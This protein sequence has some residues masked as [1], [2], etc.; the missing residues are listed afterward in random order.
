MDMGARSTDQWREHRALLEAIARNKDDGTA[1]PA[2]PAEPEDAAEEPLA[3]PSARREMVGATLLCIAAVLWIAAMLTSFEADGGALVDI[4]NRLSAASGPLALLGIGYLLLQRTSRREARRFGQTA[5]AMRAEAGALE[6]TIARLAARLDDNN[7]A[8]AEQSDRLLRIGEDSALRL[9]E[10]AADMR[11]GSETLTRQADRLEQAAATART[12]IRT[13]VDDLPVAETRIEAI[14]ARINAV[15]TD[16]HQQAATLDAALAALAAQAHAAAGQADE[17]AQRLA[18]RI[19]EIEQMG[20]ATETNIEAASGRM[21]GAIDTAYTGASEAVEQTRKGIEAQGAAMLALIDQ[22]AAVETR[23]GTV[24]DRARELETA[25]AA[26]HAGSNALTEEAGP[27]LVEALLRV[28]ETATQAAER[29]REALAEVIPAATASLGT[30]S[31]EAIE[32]AIGGQIEARM[33]GLSTSAG[34]AI[35]TA[36]KASDV[37]AERIAALDASN[38]AIEARLAEARAQAAAS[39][40]DLFAPRVALL[41]ESL[42]STAIDVAKILSNDV[43]D[44]AWMDYLKGDRS[45]FTRRAVR[46]VDGT[47]IKEIARHYDEEPEFRAQV[48]RY[49]HDFEGMLRRVLASRDG[50][51]LC[52]TLLSSD[53]GKLYVALAQ[54]IQRLRT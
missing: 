13:L 38:A 7:K 33:A 3:M 6:A 45:I 36:H 51:P 34:E 47:E 39:D 29:A 26:A 30:A 19:A 21:I 42:N 12:D 23:L 46:L 37:L 27:R 4:V 14:S 5:A 8:L 40:E 18:Q 16:T 52:V 10:L 41:I 35:A 22:A 9:V 32:Q 49:I 31:R 44:R 28:R 11:G 15:G 24:G 2:I 25:I 1:P 43:T 17:A 20:A 50:A 48:N 54:A 53:M